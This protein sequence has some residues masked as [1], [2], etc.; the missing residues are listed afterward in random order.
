MEKIYLNGDDEKCEECFGDTKESAEGAFHKY[1]NK[2]HNFTGDS[3]NQ[4]YVE[5][6]NR[7]PE[8]AL[9]YKGCERS[10]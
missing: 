2:W 3:P 7:H 5:F 4:S 1:W 8:Y 9:I 6:S 10:L